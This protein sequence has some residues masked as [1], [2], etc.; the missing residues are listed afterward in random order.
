MS[1]L[2]TVLISLAH[3][4]LTANQIEASLRRAA[5]PVVA[6]I[7][8]DRVLLDLRTVSENEEPDLERAILSL[9]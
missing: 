6:R 2:H 9:P 4:D 7:V 3:R 5:P 1:R 8:D